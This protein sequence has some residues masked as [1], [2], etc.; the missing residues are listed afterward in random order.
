MEHTS[1]ILA[2]LEAKMARQQ[3]AIELTKEHLKLIR[4]Q[5][6]D[7]E[8]EIAKIDSKK[9]EDEISKIDSKKTKG[10]E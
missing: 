10:K 1:K 2:Q 8:H 6:T 7:I 9:I 4:A 3:A 5:Q